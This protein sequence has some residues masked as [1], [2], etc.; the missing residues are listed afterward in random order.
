MGVDTIMQSIINLELLRSL[1][2]SAKSS[3]VNKLASATIKR[4]QSLKK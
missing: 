3:R 4:S 2:R 1:I